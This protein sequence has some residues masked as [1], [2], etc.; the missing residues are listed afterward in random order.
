MYTVVDFWVLTLKPESPV[1]LPK[2]EVPEADVVIKNVALAEELNEWTQA[3]SIVELVTVSSQV[4]AILCTL[5]PGK[6]KFT[7]YDQ[8]TSADGTQIE[9]HSLDLVLLATDAAKYVLQVRGSHSVQVCGNFVVPDLQ[10]VGSERD[11]AADSQTSEQWEREH[12]RDADKP[13]MSQGRLQIGLKD[14]GNGKSAPGQ[15]K[16]RSAS[17]LTQVL[18]QTGG[19]ADAFPALPAVAVHGAR[20]KSR[21]TSPRAE[22]VQK[23]MNEYVKKMEYKKVACGALY[24]DRK[25][26]TGEKIKPGDRI[27]IFWKALAE[28]G[29][30]RLEAHAKGDPYPI[31][32]G[33][34]RVSPALDEGV[35]GMRVEGERCILAPDHLVRKAYPTITNVPV[36]TFIILRASLRRFERKQLQTR[37]SAKAHGAEFGWRRG[38]PRYP[39]E[40]YPMSPSS[41]RGY[42]KRSI[43]GMPNIS[44]MDELLRVTIIAKPRRKRYNTMARPLAVWLPYHKEY[45]DELHLHNGL[46][47]NAQWVRCSVSGALWIFICI[48]CCMSSRYE[49]SII[50]SEDL[51]TTSDSSQVHLSHTCR[52]RKHCYKQQLYL[53]LLHRSVNSTATHV[54]DVAL[55]HFCHMN[56]QCALSAY[57]YYKALENMTNAWHLD[58]TPIS[59]CTR[60]MAMILANLKKAKGLRASEVG[61]CMCLHHEMWQPCG[62]GNL[63]QGERFCNMDF[64]FLS[65]LRFIHMGLIIV[66]TY[67]ITYQYF[68]NLFVQMEDF[69]SRLCTSISESSFIMKVLKEHLS[70]YEELCQ[71]PYSLNYAHSIGTM[72]GEFLK[73]EWSVLNKAAPSVKEMGPSAR[74]E[75]LEDFCNF[76]NYWSQSIK[77][78]FWH[79]M[80][81]F[82]SGIQGRS[83]SGCIWFGHESMTTRFLIYIREKN[84]ITLK[85]VCLALA[86]EKEAQQLAD[87]SMSPLS[88][89]DAFIMKER[90]L[91]Y[92]M[93]RCKQV[94]QLDE[95][96]C[97]DHR[98]SLQ[99]QL[100]HFCQLLEEHMLLLADH[101]KA[102]QDEDHVDPLVQCAPLHLPSSI[103]SDECSQLCADTLVDIELHLRK[104]L[105]YESLVELCTFLC[106]QL[107]LNLFKHHAIIKDK[108]LKEDWE[109]V[110]C[111]LNNED[112][113]ALNECAM[114]QLEMEERHCARQDSGLLEEDI[115]VSLQEPECKPTSVCE[116][117]LEREPTPPPEEHYQMEEE[118]DY[119]EPQEESNSPLDLQIQIPSNPSSNPPSSLTSSSSSNM[120]DPSISDIQKAFSAVFEL[121]NNGTNFEI[122]M[123]TS[124]SSNGVAAAIQGKLQGNLFMLVNT[125]TKC[126]E[127]MSNLTKH[128]GQ[129][130]AVVTADVKHQLFLMKCQSDGN[131]SKYLD[132]LERQHDHLTSLGRKI[133]DN[134]WINI[135]IASLPVAYRP[136][137]NSSSASI[138]TQNKIGI[139]LSTAY[140]P[141]TLTTSAVLAATIID[142]TVTPSMT[143]SPSTL[144]LLQNLVPLT[145]DSVVEDVDEDIMEEVMD[146]LHLIATPIQ[147]L[148]HP[149]LPAIIVAKTTT[150]Y[151]AVADGAKP[152]TTPAPKSSTTTTPAAHAAGPA[153]AFND[154]QWFTMATIE[155]LVEHTFTMEEQ[156]TTFTEIWDSGATCHM[157]L[158]RWMFDTFEPYDNSICLTDSTT[159]PVE[160]KGTMSINAP[161]NSRWTKIHLLNV[162][163][164]PSFCCIL[165]LL[166]K[167]VERGL[168]IVINTDEM[169]IYAPNC[170]DHLTIIPYI[171]RHYHVTHTPNQVPINLMA[172]AATNNRISLKEAHEQLGRISYRY[173]KRHL[174]KKNDCMNR[175]ICKSCL[176][177]KIL[178]TPITKC[179]ASP[180][181]A[182]F[183]D[184]IHMDVWGPAPVHTLNQHHYTVT[185]VD[186]ATGWLEEPLLHSKDEAF[187]AFIAF[188]AICRMQYG[189]SIKM[190]SSYL[191]P[192][193]VKLIDMQ[194]SST[195]TRL[196]AFSTSRRLMKYAMGNYLKFTS[197]VLE[198]HAFTS[199]S[200]HSQSSHRTQLLLHKVSV[201]HTVIFVDGSIIEG[202]PSLRISLL[203]NF[204]IPQYDPET[205]PEDIAQHEEDQK[206]ED[207]GPPPSIHTEYT[208]SVLCSMS[209]DDIDIPPELQPDD[210]ITTTCI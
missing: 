152:T 97:V 178:C 139:E 193:E 179:R 98:I 100:R 63:Q 56:L 101:L 106:T 119:E 46:A 85:D 204:N 53:Q 205:N 155:E 140:T 61:G 37:P 83:K 136:T 141:I 31:T 26:G 8:D 86:Q 127:I 19:V 187:T 94:G 190:L 131:V 162:H 133:D 84:P 108:I 71:G 48:I 125:L 208:P 17:V 210:S 54:K 148:H 110:L 35:V 11:S 124:S 170:H 156:P 75:T 207:M 209:T 142:R 137:I 154:G 168:S 199:R 76:Y 107:C 184:V 203:N 13:K 183:G 174:N 123:C 150:T 135:I 99:K 15:A 177:G 66:F 113:H 79:S 9:Q 200:I 22:D 36:N 102:T 90:E 67:D 130:T 169:N 157:S 122:W 147:Q 44:I 176:Q 78:S 74:R 173:I 50:G 186:E 82:G 5:R 40:R 28:D 159:I 73:H 10:D 185:M 163:Y 27:M 151:V 121:K 128:F 16:R 180:R 33:E 166:S 62:M 153:Y 191:L 126:H 3:R 198:D 202:E 88:S 118:L 24:Y 32:V 59:S 112:V 42:L 138:A 52:D 43:L 55:Y 20:P 4:S 111:S 129:T 49:L 47:L 105:C 38:G 25:Q 161:V 77:K 143:R 104:A 23:R 197:Y 51:C 2:S 18:D 132:D 1:L 29:Q 196:T 39:I 58:K 6:V 30:Q 81:P 114:T 93:E 146:P 72:N 68:R 145:V 87:M 103:P 7:L 41:T 120:F 171:N 64:I 57:N 96:A 21:Q 116:P 160:G 34:G 181:A 149:R 164:A 115:Y 201:E 144:H 189:I 117:T 60:F 195:T 134:T 109:T 65:V 12:N 95:A 89:L 69:S 80:Q 175:P 194:Y 206:M 92:N 188:Y 70:T 91:R 182:S 45:L 14:P 158:Y 167:F 172:F 192:Y 165:V